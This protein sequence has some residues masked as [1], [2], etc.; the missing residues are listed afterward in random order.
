VKLNHQ[1][2]GTGLGQGGINS[3]R[4]IREK[5]FGGVWVGSR[6]TRELKTREEEREARQSEKN[7]L[8]FRKEGRLEKG[9]KEEGNTFLGL[10]ASMGG[11]PKAENK[12]NTF[13]K[14]G[15]T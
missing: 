8:T 4:R 15:K 14:L 13:I 3:G 9:Q 6:R 5:Y 2:G 12:E 1:S 11:A 10:N 7:V